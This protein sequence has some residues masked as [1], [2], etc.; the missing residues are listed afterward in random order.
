MEI[1]RE[2][3]YEKGEEFKPYVPLFKN[4]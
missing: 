3:A 4:L 1:G 2:K